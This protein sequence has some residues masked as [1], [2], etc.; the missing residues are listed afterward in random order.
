MNRY[1]GDVEPVGEGVRNMEGGK[2]GW[3]QGMFRGS[4]EHRKLVTSWF[5]MVLCWGAKQ[6]ITDSHS[7]Q[8]ISSNF[9][10]AAETQARR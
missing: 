9:G 10:Q 2:S 1:R 5:A 3:E 4:G 7:R 6:L 8:L